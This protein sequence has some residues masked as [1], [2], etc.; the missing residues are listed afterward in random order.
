MPRL[1]AAN[2]FGALLSA[3]INTTATSIS[4]KDVVGTAPATPFRATLHDGDPATG[5][6]VEVTDVDG[7]TWTIIRGNNLDA[8]DQRSAASW[9]ADDHIDH[10]G[11]AGMHMELADAADLPDPGLEYFE[12]NRA[13][14][15]QV[16]HQLVVDGADVD[17]GIALSPKGDGAVTAHV[18]DGG[19]GGGNARGTH[20]VDLQTDRTANTQVASG[21]ESVV[22]GGVGNTASNSYTTVG[23]G[24][25]NTASGLG[26]TVGG[27]SDNTASQS[28]AT[29]GGGAE[30]TVSNSYATVGGGWLNT[31]S[32][33]AATVSG[34]S[35]GSAYLMGMEAYANN[36]FTVA[37]DAQRSDLVVRN[38]T[39]GA[40]PVALSLRG[41]IA[42][43]RMVLPAGKVWRFR[44]D[45]VA[46]QTAG[47]AGTVGDVYSVT[48]VG[49]IKN[50]GGTTA[51][52]GTPVYE[53]EMNDAGLAGVDV[54]VTADN[55]NDALA[56]TVTGETS[57]TI[58]WVSH[59]QLTEVGS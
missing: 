34:G 58:R 31:A 50:I 20:A 17:I 12:E 48:V 32:G 45:V 25:R 49:T 19:T 2:N 29:V 14:S 57:K 22:G 5:E 54:T 27:G 46:K 47:S 35:Y 1:Q 44:A 37:G 53:N 56:I 21:G 30:N 40:T 13:T 59:V 4:V 11:T 41:N 39:I 36:R 18:P 51:L 26:A 24:Q 6:I 9:T 55:T 28:R 3:G 43:N 38:Q 52:V 16:V 15:P 33:S 8:P 10:L 7:S 23:G 42:V